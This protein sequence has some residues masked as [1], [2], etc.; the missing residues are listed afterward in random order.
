[1]GKAYIVANKEQ[2]LNVLK[3]FEQDELVWIRKLKPTEWLPS[4]RSALV[5]FPY[6]LV[7]KGY[8]VWLSMT[9]LAGEKIVYDG[10]K[11]EKMDNKY[12]VTQE[13][14]DKVIESVL[15]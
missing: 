9:Q 5:N 8:V 13:F 12:L 11:E 3:K 7:D 10:R 4:E 2:E 14:M 1:M 6:V 15:S